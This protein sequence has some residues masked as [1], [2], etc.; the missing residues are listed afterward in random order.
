MVIMFGVPTEH[1]EDVKILL[2]AYNDLIAEIKVSK[3]T[4]TNVFPEF[5]EEIPAKFFRL[6]LKGDLTNPRVVAGQF[7]K[8]LTNALKIYMSY[9]GPKVLISDRDSI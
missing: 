9:P 6:R 4:I 3:R 8:S 7:A 5:T 1:F 2:C